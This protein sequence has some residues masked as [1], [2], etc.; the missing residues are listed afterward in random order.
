MKPEPINNFEKLLCPFCNDNN[1]SKKKEEEGFYC[2]VCEWDFYKPV[3]DISD[4]KSACEWLKEQYLK[5]CDPDDRD[6]FNSKIEEAF[7][8]VYKDE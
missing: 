8:D 5:E 2:N 6:W 3:L 7:E 1:I 4:V